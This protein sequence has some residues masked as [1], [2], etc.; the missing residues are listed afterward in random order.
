MHTAHCF[1]KKIGSR[2][3]L[4]NQ[5]NK[6]R[7]LMGNLISLKSCTEPVFP[8]VFS[9][10]LTNSFQGLKDKLFNRHAHRVSQEASLCIICHVADVASYFSTVRKVWC[11]WNAINIS[12]QK[13]QLPPG[14]SLGLCRCLS[15]FL[16]LALNC[17][18]EDDSKA[19]SGRELDRLSCEVQQWKKS[20]TT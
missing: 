20:R 18:K 13:I 4:I 7:S 5:L 11:V 2:W 19:P 8:F 9:A 1:V 10:L 3:N 15:V 14:G 16:R 17:S 6:A 12:D